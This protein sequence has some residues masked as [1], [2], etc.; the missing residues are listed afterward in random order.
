V[1]DESPNSKGRYRAAEFFAG[2]GLVRLALERKG[3]RVVFSNDID[4]EKAEIYHHNWPKD[5][6]LCVE[7]IHLLRAEEIPTC[8]LFTASFPCNDLSI[9]G[10]WEGLDGKESSPLGS[11]NAVTA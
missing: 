5:E 2:I 8:E 10:R 11:R 1:S 3:W 9:A 6:Q 4:A 7:Y